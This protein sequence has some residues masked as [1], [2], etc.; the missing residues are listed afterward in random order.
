MRRKTLT[1]RQSQILQELKNG[2]QMVQCITG[3]R[4]RGKKLREETA[5]ALAN[6]KELTLVVV[7]GRYGAWHKI[8]HNSN[9]DAFIST[10]QRKGKTIVRVTS[11]FTR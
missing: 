1:R 7:V 8:V 6:T 2:R 4:Y 10:E 11:P 3:I 9:V 5:D